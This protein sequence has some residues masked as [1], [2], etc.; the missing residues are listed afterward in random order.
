MSAQ[1]PK[2]FDRVIAG[3]SLDLQADLTLRDLF[4]MAALCSQSQED[5]TANDE[6]RAAWAYA[7]ADAMLSERAKARP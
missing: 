6:K 1:N 3:T 4:A 7:L 2:V 5:A